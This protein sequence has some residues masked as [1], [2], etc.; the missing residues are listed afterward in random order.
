MR[1]PFP[2]YDAFHAELRECQRIGLAYVAS[3][4]TSF[5]ILDAD[6]MR[7]EGK[8]REAQKME[9]CAALVARA[10][11]V[12]MAAARRGNIRMKPRKLSA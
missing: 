9:N 3:D 8:I 2:K 6:D 11:A 1:K 10:Q 4:P 7:R 12:A 5:A